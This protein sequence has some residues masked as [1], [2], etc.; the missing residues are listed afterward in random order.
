MNHD[1]E[2]MAAEYLGGAMDAGRHRAFESHLISCESCWQE[3]RL[4]RRGRRIAEQAREVAPPVLR[5]RIRAAVAAAHA[6]PLPGPAPRGAGPRRPLFFVL[7]AAL[8]TLAALA[9]ALAATHPWSPARPGGLVPTAVT[10]YATGRLPG[11][12]LPAR[13]APDL[14][15]LRLRPDGGGIGRVA[16]RELV[17]LDYQD[18]R[19]HRV[20]IYLTDSA[21][22]EPQGARQL[23]GPAMAWTATVA[24]VRVLCVNTALIL[25]RDP[26]LVT[27]V[28]R[29][30][31]LI[32]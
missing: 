11:S 22:P 15:A 26:A 5:E 4:A 24:G 27:A 18:P 20:A 10:D 29:A 19:G 16:G 30:L 1:P 7:A 17:A 2:Q 6:G 21:V 14:A 31:N 32:S 3:V 12:P 9:G 8:A 23:A 25:G 13:L 28:A